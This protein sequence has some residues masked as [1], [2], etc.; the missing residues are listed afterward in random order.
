MSSSIVFLDVEGVLYRKSSFKHS[1]VEELFPD[2]KS[3]KDYQYNIAATHFFDSRAVSCLETLLKKIPNVG[4]VVSS[5][6]RLGYNVPLLKEI[7][8]LYS[9]SELIVG[10]TPDYLPNHGR[11]SEASVFLTDTFYGRGREIACWLE[12]HDEVKEFII[13]D[14]ND[15]GLSHSFSRHFVQV[16]DSKLLTEKDVKKAVELLD[17]QKKSPVTLLFSP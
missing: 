5:S 13:L 4:I 12:K 9:F 16:D 14:D 10:K 8:A 6:W 7:F 15:S 2:V 17:G 1:K 3:H 11:D